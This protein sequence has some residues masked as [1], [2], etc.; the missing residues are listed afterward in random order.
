MYLTI[1]NKFFSYCKGIV[2]GTDPLLNLNST[3]CTSGPHWKRYKYS[4]LHD[5]LLLGY[6]VRLFY[7]RRTDFIHT[8]SSIHESL[9]SNS[10]YEKILL[11]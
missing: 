6:P 4:S 7:N 8:L 10:F 1:T 3:K 9:A 5:L 2:G 11:K